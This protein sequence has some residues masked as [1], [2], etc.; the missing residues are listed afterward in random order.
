MSVSGF[1]VTKIW[2]RFTNIK[3][4]FICQKVSQA[5]T[6]IWAFFFFCTTQ[7]TRNV[8]IFQ[9]QIRDGYSFDLRRLLHT[10][11]HRTCEDYYYLL[12]VRVLYI[13]TFQGPKSNPSNH[14]Y[15][16]PTVP[17]PDT[18]LINYSN[19]Y[20]ERAYMSYRLTTWYTMNHSWLLRVTR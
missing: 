10:V 1:M 11:R 19:N 2:E 13:V 3:Q 17:T 7:Y 8:V 14:K 15:D 5:F 18:V 9:F 6:S 20:L 16:I 4:T 12:R